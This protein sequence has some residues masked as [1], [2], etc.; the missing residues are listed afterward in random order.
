MTS[1]ETTGTPSSDIATTP[2]SFKLPIS[3]RLPYP[4]SPS[5]TEPT[6]K[7]WA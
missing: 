4:R 6:G 5:V 1:L 3:D 7:T 2:A